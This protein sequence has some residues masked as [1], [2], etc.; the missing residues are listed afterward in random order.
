MDVLKR[1]AIFAR[2]VELGAFNRAAR[3]LGL[4]TS[5]VS[6]HVRAL[7]GELG[8]VLLHRSTRKLSLTEAGRVYYEEC[9]NVV[10]AATRAQ[11]KVAE[12]R[13]EPAGELRIAAP[14]EFA[15]HHLVPALREFISAH[16]KLSIRFE[17]ADEK[18]DLI[19][20]RVDLAVRI[21][22]LQDSG[23]VARRIAWF[24]ELICAAPEYLA[25]VMVPTSPQALADLD[26]LIFTPL[27]EPAFVQLR[28]ERGQDVRLRVHGRLTTNHAQTLKALAL[29]GHGVARLLKAD[30]GDELAAGRLLQ[31]LPTWKLPG[32]GVYAITPRR[33]AQPLKVMRCIEHLRA[34]FSRLHGLRS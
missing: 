28:D 10:H 33:D 13:D 3:E 14:S 6:Q 4:T 32:F 29:D 19:E 25:R 23:L 24:D 2:V 15:H 1:M 34:Y 22:E 17:L 30:V 18:I 12:L 7:E 5:S 20:H 31:L 27:G 21:G 8:V 9:A 16:P 11:Q 26:W